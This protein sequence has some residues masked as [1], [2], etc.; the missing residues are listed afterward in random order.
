M[1]HRAINVAASLGFLAALAAATVLYERDLRD[2]EPTHRHVVAFGLDR[3]HPEVVGSV[4]LAL[5]A[6]WAS[7]LVA[8]SALRDTFGGVDLTNLAPEARIAWIESVSHIEDELRSARGLLLDAV[9]ARPGWPLHQSMLGQVILAENHQTGEP[10]ANDLWLLPLSNAADG[11]PAGW[12]HAHGA[13]LN[14][15]AETRQASGAVDWNASSFVFNAS[16]NAM[17]SR[18][19]GSVR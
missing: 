12:Q 3:R 15:T 1:I 4:S 11:A 9:A 8:D 13:G 7:E 2:R 10:V 5:S 14:V 19:R 6:D 18:R 17:R 16:A